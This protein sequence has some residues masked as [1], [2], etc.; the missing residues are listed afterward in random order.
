MGS[1]SVIALTIALASLAMALG[2]A[3]AML[4]HSKRASNHLTRKVRLSS[5]WAEIRT[6]VS[7]GAWDEWCKARP[8]AASVADVTPEM[9][10]HAM[11]A[12]VIVLVT[13][14]SYG[15]VDL[16]T[17]VNDIPYEDQEILTAEVD[18][19]LT[20]SI[21]YKRAE[22]HAAMMERAHGDS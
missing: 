10:I 14:W 19:V 16:E 21:L 8:Y 4:W 11:Q 22:E 7:Q 15:P 20:G 1:G 2:V 6:R 12:A 17:L 18:K 5:G 13:Q 3:L 9:L